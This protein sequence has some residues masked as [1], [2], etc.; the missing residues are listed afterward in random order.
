MKEKV[1]QY[2]IYVLVNK[3]FLPATGLERVNNSFL[4]TF[5]NTIDFYLILFIDKGLTT[6]FHTVTGIHLG[7]LGM[8]W[9]VDIIWGLRGP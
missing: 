4:G 1:L 2:Y 3:I 7:N 9:S 6:G 5:G 8:F